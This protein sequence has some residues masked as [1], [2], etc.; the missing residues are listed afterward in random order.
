MIPVVA[1]YSSIAE[2]LKIHPF[3]VFATEENSLS[4]LT[5]RVRSVEKDAVQVDTE[6]VGYYWASMW[7]DV[8]KD[9]KRCGSF[10]IKQ[11]RWFIFSIGA[12]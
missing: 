1:Y 2:P 6:R 12:H 7:Y 4:E 3:V 11:S 9:G 8:F 10:G 5:A